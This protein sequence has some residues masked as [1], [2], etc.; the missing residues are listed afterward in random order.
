M[1]QVATVR[2]PQQHRTE[3]EVEI[4]VCWDLHFYLLF[5]LAFL[6]IL[7]IFVFSLSRTLQSPYLPMFLPL[8][9]VLEAGKSI[10]GSTRLDFGGFFVLLF[11]SMNVTFF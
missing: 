8:M 10:A 3:V 4:G 7:A 1:Q 5:S 6:G 11:S 9:F 2:T